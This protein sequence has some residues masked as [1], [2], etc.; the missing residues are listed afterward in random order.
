M[1]AFLLEGLFTGALE[2]TALYYLPLF[3]FAYG[4]SNGEIGLLV[5]AAS[6]GAATSSL[7]GAWISEKWQHRKPFVLL[8]RSANVLPLLALALLP[9]MTGGSMI[10]GMIIAAASMRSFVTYLGEGA[11]TSLAADLVPANMRGRFF[12]AR[13]LLLGVGGLA[14]V[15]AVALLLAGLDRRTEWSAVWLLALAMGIGASLSYARIPEGELPREAPPT[16]KAGAHWLTIVRDRNFMR[17]CSTVFVWN[18]ALYMAAPFLNVHLVKNLGASP[19]WVGG[20]LATAIVFGSAGQV[21][22]G[23]V[24]DR[25]PAQSLMIHSGL[26]VAIVPLAWC[27]AR[28]PWQV[29]PINV[30]GGIAW[31]AYLLASF[32]FLLAISPAGRERYYAGAYTM[33]MFLSLTIGPLLGGAIAAVYGIKTVLIA[34]GLGRM[35]ATGL[36]A[37]LVREE[38]Y[39]PRHDAPRRNAVLSSSP[40]ST[41]TPRLAERIPS[42]TSMFARSE[43]R[44]AS[45]DV[46]PTRA[47]TPTTIASGSAA[48][49][50]ELE[51]SPSSSTPPPLP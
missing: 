17:Y 5:A 3:A 51:T 36:F 47:S 2:T 42:P 6:L 50:E 34:A 48:T 40:S 7:P 8:T 13:N 49:L 22:F 14:A 11:W 43:A 41:S 16:V 20:L 9:F 38:K 18:V 4:A 19:L 12:A 35:A 30:F 45:S 15:A 26:A 33:I 32:N 1:R 25:R 28:E 46:Q 29:I 37:V 44:V 31:A 24:A 21:V 27:F 10:L 39:E 23:R